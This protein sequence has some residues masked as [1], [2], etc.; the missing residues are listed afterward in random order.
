MKFPRGYTFAIGIGRYGGFY[1]HRGYM[2]RVCLGWVS[3]TWCPF[4]IDDLI[5]RFNELRRGVK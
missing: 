2:L 1:V 3:L 4:E 5:Q